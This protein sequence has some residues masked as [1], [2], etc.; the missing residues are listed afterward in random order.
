MLTCVSMN[1]CKE[2]PGSFCPREEDGCSYIVFIFPHVLVYK[3]IFTG[4]LSAV[5]SWQKISIPSAS[6]MPSSSNNE[7][8]VLGRLPMDASFPRPHSLVWLLSRVLMG[9]GAQTVEFR[10]EC[11]WPGANSTIWAGIDNSISVLGYRQPDNLSWSIQLS[12]ASAL[13]GIMLLSRP[14]PS[15]PRRGC[16]T[17][18]DANWRGWVMAEG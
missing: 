14:L 10:E 2:S 18:E 13:E 1:I 7:G 9:E 17:D 8:F 4:A 15:R 6:P 16:K 12:E 5:W 11:I 3:V